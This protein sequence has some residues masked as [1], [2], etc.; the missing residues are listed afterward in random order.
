MAQAASRS[1]GDGTTDRAGRTPGQ[2]FALA[3]GLVYLLVGIVGFFIT[4]F[5]GFA[6]RDPS[7]ALLIFWINPLH[8]IT[9]ILVGALWLASSRSA[10]AARTTNLVIGV[11]YL[12][13]GLLGLLDLGI[14]ELINNNTG[15]GWLHVVSGAAALYFGTKGAEPAGRPSTV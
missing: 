10:T 9:H 13:L 14:L 11:V 6:Q 12:V 5:D 8:N 2:L 15:D 4:G 7:E 3:F 1:G